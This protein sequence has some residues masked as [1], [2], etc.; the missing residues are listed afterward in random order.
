[1]LMKL[2]KQNIKLNQIILLLFLIIVLL[3]GAVPG[4]LQKHW[5]WEKP[6]PVTTISQM[7]E[8]RKKGLEIPG[9]Q[10]KISKEVPVSREKWLYQEVQIDPQTT[11]ILLLR[12]Q[13]DDKDQ[14]QVQWV[15]VKG[16][17]RWQTDRDRTVEFTIPP[18][19]QNAQPTTVKAKYFRGWNRQQTF[20]VLQWYAWYSGGS[21]DPASWFWSDQIA[22]WQGKRVP[23]VAVSIQ[24]PIEPLGDI[25][26]VL[27]QAKSL[28]Q[29]VQTALMSSSLQKNKN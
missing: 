1:M 21:P 19:D 9:W 23:W 2:A 7:R 22:Q 29:A 16:F 18:N 3:V 15:D 28:G 27:P 6:L 26:P 8:I 24:I 5:S 20:A 25:E 13:K 17:Q 4:Y 10:S 12:P 11:A 14:P